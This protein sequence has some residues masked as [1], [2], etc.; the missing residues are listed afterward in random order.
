[1]GGCPRGGRRI[2]DQVVREVVKLVVAE[3]YTHFKTTTH[4]GG[5]G[6]GRADAGQLQSLMFSKAYEGERAVA[7]QSMRN[8]A[9]KQREI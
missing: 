3:R 4:D 5:G 7:A 6:K 1:M 8:D 2:S 9:E